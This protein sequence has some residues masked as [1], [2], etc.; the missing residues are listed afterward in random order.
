MRVTYLRDATNLGAVVLT[1]LGTTGAVQSPQIS[2]A[3]NPTW[4]GVT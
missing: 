1:C 2:M 4:G 3:T